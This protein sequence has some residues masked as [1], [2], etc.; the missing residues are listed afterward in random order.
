MGRRNKQLSK[1]SSRRAQERELRKID[2]AILKETVF[3][4]DFFSTTISKVE[5]DS[6]CVEMDLNGIKFS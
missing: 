6:F 3:S 4:D 2:K 1:R 5:D